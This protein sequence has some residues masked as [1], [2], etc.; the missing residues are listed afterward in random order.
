MTLRAAFRADASSAVGVGH[1]MRSLTLARAWTAAGGRAVMISS[2]DNPALVERIQSGG[3]SV[4]R[5]TSAKDDL[6]LGPTVEWARGNAS[7]WVCL[8]GYRFGSEY[9][10]A[11]RQA[12]ARL[13]VIDDYTRLDRYDADL[14][15]DQNAGAESRTYPVPAGVKTLLGPGYALIAPEF[16]ALRDPGRPQPPV[17]TNIL[18]TFGGADPANLTARVA[19]AMLGV[20]DPQVQATFVLGAANPNAAEVERLVSGRVGFR[21]VRN[22][23]DMP[24]LMAWAH[25]AITATG[26]TSWE[27]C[28]MG[29]PSVSIV[30]AK[31]QEP[32]AQALSAAGVFRDLGWH[33]NVSVGAIRE[34][35]AGLVS[36]QSGRQEMA[37]RGQDMVDGRGAGRVVREMLELTGR[38]V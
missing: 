21:V 34:A 35:I 28:T 20:K 14:L 32:A 30:L 9:Q 8:D 19:A 27:L 36:D 17:A 1:L 18:V 16:T 25:M 31:N 6:G 4:M 26:T 22:A 10:A 5:L 15:L 37:R 2:T 24:R 38:A 3:I 33:A 29:V 23:A 13:L 11:L 7:G 12:G